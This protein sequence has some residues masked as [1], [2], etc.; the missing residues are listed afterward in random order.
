M[1]IIMPIMPIMPIIPKSPIS[2][3][4]WEIVQLKGILGIMRINPRP[5]LVTLLARLP[6]MSLAARPNLHQLL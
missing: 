5:L 4:M 6:V 2:K 3:I 1:M